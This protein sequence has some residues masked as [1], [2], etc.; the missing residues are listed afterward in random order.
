MTE[1]TYDRISNL[2]VNSP[3]LARGYAMAHFSR[4]SNDPKI[5]E[6][7]R[8]IF[9]VPFNI[10]DSAGQ[11]FREAHDGIFQNR[12]NVRVPYWFHT[13][14][15]ASTVGFFLGRRP[16]SG[17]IT[18][19]DVIIA[20][21]GHD[22]LEDVEPAGEDPEYLRVTT[23]ESRGLIEE[24]TNKFT[25]TRYPGMNRHERKSNELKRLLGASPEAKFIK[26]ADIYAN[27]SDASELDNS[28]A[29]KYYSEK[30]AF[31]D[32]LEKNLWF[33]QLIDWAVHQV[34][35]GLTYLHKN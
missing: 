35:E 33:D 12:D 10:A 9:E 20:A 27:T 26:V 11:F 8:E 5:R 1:Q 23:P 30:L 28:F 21:L 3:D 18:N 7:I 2:N 34:E 16:R 32:S 6:L 14:E 29:R 24:L 22:Y 25:S 15:V 31:L 4:D 19:R 17:S 13:E